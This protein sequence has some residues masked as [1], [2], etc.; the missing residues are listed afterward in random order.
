M[1]EL[2]GRGSCVSCKCSCIVRAG[3]GEDRRLSAWPG[4]GRSDPGGYC[5][6]LSKRSSPEVR[7]LFV[8]GSAQSISVLDDVGHVRGD[9]PP[10]TW[11]LRDALA[12]V[13]TRDG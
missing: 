6:L 2:S 3:R 10:L 7:W 12:R 1:V 13:G 9:A 5:S 11:V 4:E 8:S